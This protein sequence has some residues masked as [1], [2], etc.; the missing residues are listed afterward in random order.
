MDNL[1]IE[2]NWN[3]GSGELNYGKYNT[4][5]K[6]KVNDEILLNGDAATEYGG[7]PNN[8][9]PEQALTAAMSSCHML[10]F[11]A[12]AAKMKWP[13]ITYADKAIAYLGKNSKNQFLTLKLEKIL[14]LD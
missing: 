11:L 9:N 4:K 5:H 6:I 8:L 7:N 13:V 10:T 3:I 2:L 1:S 14:T 12:L